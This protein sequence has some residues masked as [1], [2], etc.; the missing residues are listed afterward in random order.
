[1]SLQ[2]TIKRYFLIVSLVKQN[3]RPSSADLLDMLHSEGFEI[4]KRTLDRD[5]ED[6]RNEF[7]IELVYDKT[8]KGYFIDIKQTYNLEY[9]LR[10]FELSISA[11]VMIDSF[12]EGKEALHF[13]SF[14]SSDSLTG[15]H[16]L[17]DLMM[18]IRTRRVV[19][20]EHTSFQTGITLE[21]EVHPY[22]LKEFKARW[23][24]YAY[25][26]SLN[27]F[28]IFGIERIDKLMLAD[29]YYKPIKN[30]NPAE[31]FEHIIGISLL[32]FQEQ[33]IQTIVISTTAEQGRYMKSLP[34]HP[35]FTPLV[36]TEDEFRFSLTIMPNSEFIQLMLYYCNRVTVIQPQ[37]LRDTLKNILS[38]AASKY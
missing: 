1:M 25:V 30:L 36:D 12:K 28:R 38:E 20:F 24:L 19:L 26:P 18:A 10:F 21:Y 34:W 22:F 4:S 37:W 8:K 2:G 29:E 9:I 14:D 23:F 17:R 32:P 11:Q 6:I 5:I 35:S 3:Q 31:K 16:W 33:V 27:D 13:L 7:G 15:V